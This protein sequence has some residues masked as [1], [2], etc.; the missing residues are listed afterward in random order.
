MSEN[1]VKKI[2]DVSIIKFISF[3]WS[4]YY[5][6]KFSYNRQENEDLDDSIE[7]PS[8][9]LVQI[10]REKNDLK[11]KYLNSILLNIDEVS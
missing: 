1:Q 11:L 6:S 2:S 8:K 5:L 4:L 7:P 9:D 3:L 10:A